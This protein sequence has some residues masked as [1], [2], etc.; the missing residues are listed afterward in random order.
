M[1]IDDEI[2][3]NVQMYYQIVRDHV[4]N[5]GKSNRALSTLRIK[6][7]AFAND[8]LQFIHKS[9]LIDHYFDE[10]DLLS[11]GGE[12]LTDAKFVVNV[13]FPGY[14]PSLPQIMEIMLD[15][16]NM[17]ALSAENYIKYKQQQLTLNKQQQALL[18][19]K[20]QLIISRYNLT[21][22]DV[23]FYRQ[24]SANDTKV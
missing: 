2:S 19:H 5:T 9:Y 11:D 23:I 24:K 14:L 15:Y 4:Y 1:F 21:L 8:A 12:I 6:Q 17:I 10:L 13:V 20:E 22:S 3:A 18:L 7:E 16:D